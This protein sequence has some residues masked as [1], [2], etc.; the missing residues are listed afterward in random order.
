[1]L[2][3]VILCGGSGTRLWPLSRESYPKQFLDLTGGGHS[4]LQ[5]TLLRLQGIDGLSHPLVLCNHSH[6]FLVAE[7]LQALAPDAR[8]LLEPVARNTAPAAAV[9]AFAALEH[10]AD[11]Q[12]LVLPADHLIGDIAALHQAIERA[13]VAAQAGHL[14][15]FGVVP[16]AAETGFGYIRRAG[17]L[18][19]ASDIHR[20]AEFVEKPSLEKAEE[21]LACGEYTWNSGMFLF[22]A[23]AYLQALQSQQPAMYQC[24]ESAFAKAYR[25]LDFTR[26]DADDFAACPQDSID[27]AVMESTDAGAVVP[28]DAQWSDVGSWDGLWDISARDAQGNAT[29]GDTELIDSRNNL[30]HSASRLVTT[31]GL[32]DTIVVETA[33]AVLV[34][35]REQSQQVKQIVENLRENSRPEVSEHKT[36][37]RPWGSYQSICASDRFQVKKILVNPGQKLSLQMH[38]H[39]AEHWVVVKGT[40]L[41]TCEDKEFTLSE[42]QSTYIPIG[43]RHRLENPGRIPLELIEV[44]S[45]TYLGEDDIVRFED[46]YGR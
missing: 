26:L 46:V 36:V 33:D 20:I 44:Q 29:V 5:Q 8:L 41:V 2:F 28:L 35:A 25:D 13:R 10:S 3:P 37:F 11:A 39:R 45:G 9:A 43:H 22:R 6:R 21:Y 19:D 34:A 31:L 4:L 18:P 15:T 42:D 24:C 30:V 12:L 40:A 23:D 16:T 32:E 1:M 7:Q 38:H 17:A 14:V 27:Y